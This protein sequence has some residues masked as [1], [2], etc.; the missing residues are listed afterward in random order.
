MVQKLD[1]DP[2]PMSALT[3]C[4]RNERNAPLVSATELAENADNQPGQEPA[5]GAGT[6]DNFINALR[7]RQAPQPPLS[8]D[9]IKME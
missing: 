3:D 2:A 1:F 7:E 9:A 5:A 8:N 6:T 4:A